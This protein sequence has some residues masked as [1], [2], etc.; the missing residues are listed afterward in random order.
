MNTIAFG[1]GMP[2]AIAAYR[3]QTRSA[4]GKS[5]A[6]VNAAASMRRLSYNRSRRAIG[7]S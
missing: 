2:A 1:F 5:P 3:S 4:A 7:R 6:A